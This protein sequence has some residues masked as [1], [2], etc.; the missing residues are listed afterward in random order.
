[1]EKED[2]TWLEI[3]QDN[4]W[5]ELVNKKEPPYCLEP[6][7]DIIEEYNR[8]HEK[9]VM[10]K[11]RPS[12]YLGDVVNSKIFLL[13]NNPGHPY[14]NEVE[15]FDPD[16]IIEKWRDNILQNGSNKY[17][18]YFLDPEL[19]ERLKGKKEEGAKYF[20]RFFGGNKKLN[21]NSYR[22]LI[23]KNICFVEYFPYPTASNSG[24]P[25]LN[26]RVLPSQEFTFRIIK[27]AIYLNKII[28]VYRGKKYWM[29]IREIADYFSTGN[30]YH[31]K[32]P[33]L[34]HLTK[35]GLTNNRNE[36][37]DIFQKCEE[38]V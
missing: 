17:P 18:L 28:I 38:F 29:K 24:V 9:K 26:G 25:D 35:G 30:L 15:N 16:F 19:G 3:F 31:N 20:T 27:Q 6:D 33:G 23:A 7:R 13:F 36:V 8:T 22:E 4:P 34:R 12:P 2:E 10:L 37:L 11:R 32:H 14:P 1:M 5:K 21:Q